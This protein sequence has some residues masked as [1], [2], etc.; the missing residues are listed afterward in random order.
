MGVQGECRRITATTDCRRS[1]TGVAV[2]CWNETHCIEPKLPCRFGDPID[3]ATNDCQFKQKAVCS[4]LFDFTK[5]CRNAAVD[6][7][8]PGM[9]ESAPT[10]V[11]KDDPTTGI[12][13]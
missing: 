6:C 10:C 7:P 8:P 3:C 9:G 4:N 11:K 1:E 13:K 2:C 5:T 12:C